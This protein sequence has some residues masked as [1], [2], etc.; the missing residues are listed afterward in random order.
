LCENA[1]RFPRREHDGKLCRAG[2][3]LDVIDEIEFSIEHLLVKK[4]QRAESL[5]LSGCGDAL[6]N[7]EMGKEVGD[8]FL[9][10]FV[11]VAFAMKE[12]VTANPIDVRLFGADR[13][14]F[15]PQVPPDAI[16]QLGR[17]SHGCGGGRHA[18]DLVKIVALWQA[19]MPAG[20]PLAKSG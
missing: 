16:E 18:E 14:M 20:S 4:Q 5:I 6:F 10:H 12:N 7:G 15:H 8:F 2:N 19:D 11:R 13:I 17:G 3:A 1:A 9:A